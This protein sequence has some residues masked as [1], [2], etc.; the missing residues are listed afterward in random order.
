MITWCFLWC[1]FVNV[2]WFGIP[3]CV[4]DKRRAYF[5]GVLVFKVASILRL[6]YGLSWL[7]RMTFNI[8]GLWWCRMSTV[9]FAKSWGWLTVPQASLFLCTI[10]GAVERISRGGHLSCLWPDGLSSIWL[11]LCW[12]LYDSQLSIQELASFPH[13]PPC[14]RLHPADSHTF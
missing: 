9:S 2:L 5:S 1:V 4:M 6:I 13:N 10:H 8:N 7:W 14:T 11:Y 12:K 3:Q